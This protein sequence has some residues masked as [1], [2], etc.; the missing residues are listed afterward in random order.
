MKSICGYCT[1]NLDTRKKR[2]DH[3]LFI[4]VDL[5]A[6]RSSEACPR[7]WNQMQVWSFYSTVFLSR[8]EVELTW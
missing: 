2:H 3:P 8:S 7:P 6:L 1:I 4:N 5:E